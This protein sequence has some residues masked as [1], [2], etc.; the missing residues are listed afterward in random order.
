[1]DQETTGGA[2]PQ[3]ALPEHVILSLKKYQ[4]HTTLTCLEC[5]YTGLMGV[6]RTTR[7]WYLSWWLVIAFFIISIPFGPTAWWIPLALGLAMAFSQKHVVEC[8]SCGV[9]LVATEKV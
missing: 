6:K 7:P 3:A 9:E 4:K 5:G 8:P 1:M 2:A